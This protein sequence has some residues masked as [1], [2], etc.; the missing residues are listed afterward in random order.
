MAKIAKVFFKNVEN[1]PQKT[2]ISCDGQEYTYRE[3]AYLVNRWSHLMN[4]NGIKY[5][6][7][8]GVLLHNS[9]DFVALMLVAANIGAALV[10]LSPGLPV[11][12][13]NKAFQYS[14]VKHIVGNINTF[15]NL[16]PSDI[17]FADGLWLCMD[18]ELPHA[19]SFQKLI[20][21]MPSE[22]IK[23][24]NMGENEPFILTMT[25]GST[26]E[27]KPIV[28]TQKNKYD[29]AFAAIDLYSIT[30]SDVILAST[31]LYH[32]LAERLV[33]LPLLIGATSILMPRFSASEWLKCIQEN[34][35]S[36][37]IA[38]SSQLKQIA[39]ILKYSYPPEIESLRCIVSSS[40]LLENHVKG[41]LL[42]KLNCDFH[43]CYG[44]SEISIASNLD[45]N[46]AKTKL[47]S[48]GKPAPN[49][50]IKILKEDGKFANCEEAGEII[51]KTPLLFGGYYK[52]QELTNKAMFGEYF[53][54]GDIG[55]LDKDGFLYFLDRKKDIIITGGINAYPKDIESV[56]LEL[57]FIEEC[58]AFPF[59]DEKL[60]EI[61][62]V[63]IVPKQNTEFNLKTVKFHC[64]RYLA[65][66]QQPRKYFTVDRLPKNNMGKLT[67]HRLIEQ[68]ALS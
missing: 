57:S 52:L 65:D 6:D 51:C 49:T 61:I 30:S 33:L 34:S 37:T 38:V 7:N 15:E 45:K 12:A 39:E 40:A 24:D 48:V 35:V 42:S 56:I 27:P 21:E 9:I 22:P 46:N 41:E 17:L 44:T 64:A 10:P 36:F 3:L 25:S 60:G 55:Y 19:Q 58:A 5:G 63:A 16:I 47:K 11:S 18:G 54:T 8:I 28:L 4:N 68:F 31:P 53:R 67:K 14:D 1:N 26:G 13:I 23:N 59:P 50:D 2:A 32:S 20:S 66:F 29:R 43:E 62:A